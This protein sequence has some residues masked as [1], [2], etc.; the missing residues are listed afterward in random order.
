MERFKHLCDYGLKIGVL[1]TTY[2]KS[3]GSG[4][5]A[6]DLIRKWPEMVYGFGNCLD[7]HPDTEEL[8]KWDVAADD[9]SK[10]WQSTGWAHYNM[11]D[12][13]VVQ[14]GI[15]QIIA[16]TEQFGW[17]A[18][19]FDGHFRAR[20]GKQP[21]DGATVEFTADAADRQTAANQ[22]TLKEQALARFPRYGF[23]YNYAECHFDR[24]LEAQ[25][26]ETIELCAG[27][28]LIMDEYARGNIGGAHPYRN[29][30]DFAEMLVRENEQIRR[31]GGHLLPLVQGGLIGRYQ[32]IFILAAGGHPGM[33]VPGGI[34]H[35]YNAFATRY[36]SVLWHEGVRN[37]WNPNGMI[38]VP[39]TVWWENYVRVHDL[40]SKHRRLIVHL[41]NAPPHET[42]TETAG[43][44]AEAKRRTQRRRQIAVAA[45]TKKVEPDFSEIDNLTPVQLTPL[46]ITDVP[47][48]VVPQ[49]FDRPWQATRALLLDPE[50]TT[51]TTLEIDRSDPYFWE[52]RI[53]KLEFWAV[54][55]VE[56]EVQP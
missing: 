51:R 41:I 2:G 56:L 11:N 48:R 47:V 55:V 9:P 36:S 29:W 20:S 17:A 23:G 14:H 37:L 5:A 4:S 46:P 40:D 15:D 44:I 16:S 43:Q 32:T 50:T 28:G 52:L 24:R 1:P 22:E 26:R 19:R 35:P 42:A 21:V 53:P 30:A 13:K 54:I 25:P 12:P 3:I 45:A 6:R 39:D 10:E 27:N 31:L 38:I 33:A 7:F 34:D 18:V 49:A 8:A